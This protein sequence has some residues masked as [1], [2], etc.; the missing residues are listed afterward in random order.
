MQTEAFPPDL[1]LSHSLWAAGQEFDLT[2]LIC[3]SLSFFFFAWDLFFV[4]A[5]SKAEFASLKKFEHCE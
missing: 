5:K 4:V 3:L 1:L 2:N